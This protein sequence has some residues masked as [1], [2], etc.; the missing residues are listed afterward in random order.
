VEA[1]LKDGSVRTR[2][3]DKVVGHPTHPMSMDDCEEKFW[4]CAPFAANP[5]ARDKLEQAVAKVRALET[6]D[7]VADIVRML[8]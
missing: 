5:I 4:S 3:S 8:S 2:R 7:D 1:T 6:C